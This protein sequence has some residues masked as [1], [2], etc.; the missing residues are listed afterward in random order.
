ML[1][2]GDGQSGETVQN[3]QV[4]MAIMN[5]RIDSEIAQDQRCNRVPVARTHR[6]AGDRWPL[7]RLA[8]CDEPSQ[9]MELDAAFDEADVPN[10]QR[11]R[12]RDEV[13]V[14]A[15]FGSRFLAIPSAGSDEGYRRMEAF[16]TTVR[17]PGLP[18]RLARAISGAARFAISNMCSWINAPRRALVAGQP[19]GWQ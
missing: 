2:P 18:Q 7:E 16:V 15:G 11:D 6:W 17:S 9:T 8:F 12:L 13:R 14:D 3:E 5:N 19:G 4:L 10:W 1:V